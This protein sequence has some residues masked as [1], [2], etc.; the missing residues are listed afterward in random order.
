MDCNHL[1]R[2]MDM[3]IVTPDDA[4]HERD[5]RKHDE[6]DLERRLD[7]IIRELDEFITLMVV[8][9]NNLESIQSEKIAFGQIALRVQLILSGIL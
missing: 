6:Y 1:D 7:F 5:L 3:H 4:D 8:N 9:S 2:E